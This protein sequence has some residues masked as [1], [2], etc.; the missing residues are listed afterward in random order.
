MK[1]LAIIVIT[2]LSLVLSMVFIF[3]NND[4]YSGIKHII[5]E[6]YTRESD[7]EKLG[8]TLILK[9]Q[10][11]KIESRNYPSMMILRDLIYFDN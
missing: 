6:K 9:V 10:F 7:I 2:I 4:D 3:R 11:L 8:D 5:K 1:R